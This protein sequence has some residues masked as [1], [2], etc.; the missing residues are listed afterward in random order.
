MRLVRPKHVQS[1]P[2]A[3]L[4]LSFH[5]TVY[6]SRSDRDGIEKTACLLSFAFVSPQSFYVTIRAQGISGAPVHVL[7]QLN[8]SG[9]EVAI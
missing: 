1:T 3:A 7:L 9:S 8:V 4:Y 5:L 6:M 2:R